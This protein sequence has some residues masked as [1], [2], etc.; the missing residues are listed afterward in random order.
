MD[1]GI[2]TTA[3]QT[4]EPDD[5]ALM[6]AW[7]G[8]DVAAFE[9]LYARHRAPLY[10]FLMRQLRNAAL[11]DELF[12]DVWQRVI[13][14]RAGWKPEA[15]FS[16]WLYRIAHNRLNDHWRSLKHRPPAPEDGDER[17]ARIPDPDTPERT[18]TEFEQRRRLQ[19]AIEELP[20]EQRLVV[21]LRLEQELSLEEIGEITGVGRETVKSR[22]RY[23]MDKLRARLN[24]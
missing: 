7:A 12:Q 14:A 24:E 17:A 6:L 21:S 23:A 2:D 22:L 16:T 20:D 11:A 19:R 8:G 1:S 15:A 13:G 18:L 4:A 5:A 9:Q 10:R 3:L